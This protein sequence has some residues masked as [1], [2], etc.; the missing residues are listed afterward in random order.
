RGVR[1]GVCAG[2][3]LGRNSIARSDSGHCSW[4]LFLHGCWAGASLL[5]LGEL[6]YLDEARKGSCLLYANKEEQ[7][8][9]TS[10]SA[11]ETIIHKEKS[12]HSAQEQYQVKSRSLRRRI[13]RTVLKQLWGYKPFRIC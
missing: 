2:G 9:A 12:A 13:E 3:S 5:V 7:Y 4:F 10:E 11:S 8:Q 1:A 6:V